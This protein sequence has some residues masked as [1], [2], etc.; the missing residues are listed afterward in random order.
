MGMKWVE[1]NPN[2]AKRQTDDCTVR[3]LSVVLGCT[4]DEAAVRLDAE[5]FRL[6]VMPDSK[7]AFHSLLKGL[8]FKRRIIPDTC[9][10]CYTVDDFR[11]E[12]LKGVYVLATEDHVVAVKDGVIYDSFDSS[13]ENP[14]F[15]WEE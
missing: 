3:A 7:V 1:Y 8:G 10:D 9:P 15:Y 4:W 13:A 2:P 12:H 6:K 5:A 11:V 14:Q